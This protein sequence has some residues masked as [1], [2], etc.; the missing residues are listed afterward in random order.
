[1]IRDVTA[2]P[3]PLTSP[4]KIKLGRLGLGNQN[5][6]DEANLVFYMVTILGNKLLPINIACQND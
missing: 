6:R 4:V 5:H 2:S 1:M 3:S